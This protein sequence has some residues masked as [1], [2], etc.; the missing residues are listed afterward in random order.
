MK[1]QNY[2]TALQACDTLFKFCE[3]LET[4]DN[5]E[6]CP[7]YPK[8]PDYLKNNVLSQMMVD[9]KN[10]LKAKMGGEE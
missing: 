7:L 10:I 1:K 9:F 3:S 5:C 2:N 6:T 8:C 4:V